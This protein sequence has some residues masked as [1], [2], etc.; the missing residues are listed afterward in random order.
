M[1]TRYLQDIGEADGGRVYPDHHF[2]WARARV[3]LRLDDHISVVAE[4]PANN[5][6]HFLSPSERVNVADQNDSG[7]PPPELSP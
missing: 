2:V 4:F 7:V 5:G 3:R 1:L 6:S